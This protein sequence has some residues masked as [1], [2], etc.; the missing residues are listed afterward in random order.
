MPRLLLLL[1][2][3]SLAPA[4]QA[5]DWLSIIGTEDGRPE[6]AYQPIGFLQLSA[7]SVLFGSEVTGLES[8]ALRPYEGRTPIF[9]EMAEPVELAIRRA[10]FGSRGT[11]PGTDRR[12]NYLLTLEAGMNAATR[13]ANVVLMDAS[14]TL[15]IVPGLRLR[16][17]QMKLPTM[18]EAIEVN[19][20][21][22]TAVRFSSLVSQLLL[23][24]PLDAGRLTG[25]AYALRDIG[26]MAFDSVRL[27]EKR[28]EL[29]YALLW[30]QG[31][32]GGFDIDPHKDVTGRV[33]L[34]W[35]FDKRLYSPHR[36]DVSVFV[37]G[38]SGRRELD[39]GS[40]NRT[41]AGAGAF[42]RLAPV[43]VRLEGVVAEGALL[44]S[45]A[46]EGMDY[47]IL[48]EG[49]AAGYAFDLGLTVYGPFVLHAQAEELYRQWQVAADARILRIVSLGGSWEMSAKS[50]LVFTY[51]FRQLDAPFG[52]ADAQRIAAAMGD[53][54]SAQWTVIF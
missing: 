15:R 14:V 33:Q 50:R 46:F 51:A 32:K 53:H 23:E 19:P 49:R 12:V 11:I 6:V 42:F 24:Q 22:H 28:L 45:P 26:I 4:A 52:S 16:F 48:P 1:W 18:D 3:L 47:R 34:A 13:D 8:E 41:R 38:T 17:G 30:S 39:A 43:Q 35:L 9:N 25:P 20:L 5:A 21:V 36:E 37:W 44:Q 10:R 7:E 31:R 54:A 27:L 2:L 40:V 29:S